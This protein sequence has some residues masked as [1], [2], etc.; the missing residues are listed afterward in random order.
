M[1]RP[2]SPDAICQ[3]FAGRGEDYWNI[4]DGATKA[5]YIAFFLLANHLDVSDEV[6]VISDQGESRKLP[7]YEVQQAICDELQTPKGLVSTVMNLMYEVN[8]DDLEERLS[9]GENCAYAGRDEFSDDIDWDR[10]FSNAKLCWKL[11]S[12]NS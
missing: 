3:Y 10:L 2:S 11:V 7:W 12:L 5:T 1:K 6:D 9:I 4:C 8:D